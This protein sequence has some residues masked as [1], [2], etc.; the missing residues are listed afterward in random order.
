MRWR[1]WDGGSKLGRAHGVRMQ[2]VSQRTARR[3]HTHCETSC[4]H[5]C[6]KEERLHQRSGSC[7]LSSS[8]R[9]GSKA[10]RCRYP[11]TTSEA[12]NRGSRQIGEEEF[13]DHARTRDANG[14]LLFASWMC[15][16]HHSARHALGSHLHRLAVVEA[17]HH[18]AFRAL[19]ELIGG[20][21]Q[22]RLDERMI[23]HGVLF[24]ARNIGEASQVSQHGPGAILS[25]EPEEGEPLWELVRRE[26]ARDRREGL[27]QFRSVATVAPVA[28]RA[29]P[30]FNYGSG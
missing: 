9:A 25:I 10:P 6:P 15:R 30:T 7:S 4:Q 12:V 11:S 19:L 22:T 3:F 24:A 26:G 8:A 1:R 5:S 23:E 28:K 17:A 27:A 18:L 20:Q 2:L 16:H 29:E 21:V 13:V 14:A